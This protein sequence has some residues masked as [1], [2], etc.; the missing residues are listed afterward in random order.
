MI[1]HGGHYIKQCR[2]SEIHKKLM[3]HRFA[4]PIKMTTP[5][6]A[7]ELECQ[8]KAVMRSLRPQSPIQGSPHF[9]WPRSPHDSCQFRSGG[10][11]VVITSQHI[12][13]AAGPIQ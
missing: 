5:L 11:T 6:K 9:T 2:A 12:A 13:K 10:I 4:P 7:V 1:E 8:A 3:N